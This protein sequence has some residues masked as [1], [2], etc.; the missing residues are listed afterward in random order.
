LFVPR[1][2]QAREHLARIE[3]QIRD[4]TEGSMRIHWTGVRAISPDP[5]GKR[6]TLVPL[7][8]YQ[9]NREQYDAVERIAE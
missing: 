7:P 3:Q 8:V 9:A 6:R 1:H 5:S 4:L 2:A